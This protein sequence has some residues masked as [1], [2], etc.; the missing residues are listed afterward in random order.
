MPS[1]LKPDDVVEAGAA[2]AKRA[3]ALRRGGRRL[4]EVR[5]EEV[6]KDGRGRESSAERAENVWS[7]D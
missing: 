2:P 3:G 7:R 4:N 6:L 5:G 1:F